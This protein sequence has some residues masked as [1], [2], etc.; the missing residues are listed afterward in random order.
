MK[1]STTANRCNLSPMRKFH[2]LAVK[3]K[4]EG[5]SIYHLNI[6]QP[7]LPTPEEFFKATQEFSQNTLAYAP[8]PGLPVLV[9]AI[10]NYYAKL[11]IQ[12]EADDIFITTGGSE[13]L[14]FTCLSILDPH[15]EVIIRALLS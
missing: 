1:I 10:R 13:A 9:E 3:A 15:T 7:D 12:Y 6:G 2:P 11:G 4:S 14:L 5:K 8:S